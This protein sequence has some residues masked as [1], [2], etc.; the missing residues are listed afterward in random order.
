MWL[1]AKPSAH[2][3]ASPDC[4]GLPRLEFN[5]LASRSCRALLLV[6]L[7]WLTAPRLMLFLVFFPRD[8]PTADGKTPQW[9]VALIVGFICVLHG[10]AVVIISAAFYMARPDLLSLWAHIL[11]IT[12]TVL[13]CV[14][15]FPQ[16]WTT[17]T[18]RHIG[19][20]S[21]PMM[22]IQTPGSFLWSG[23]LA[24]RLGPG[25]WSTWGVFL[26]TG[27]LQGCLLALAIYF[28][29][30]ARREGKQSAPDGPTARNAGPLDERTP[31]LDGLP[32]GIHDDDG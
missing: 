28:E 12:A 23:S 31:L 2:S 22:L 9:R 14:Q 32:N 7:P 1:V 4:L 17:Y 30:L 10:L 20:L 6:A 11:G 16:I 5:G 3:N 24:A 13:A 18:L 19:S 29:V 25:G 8:E 21:I 15:Y 26:V 27:C